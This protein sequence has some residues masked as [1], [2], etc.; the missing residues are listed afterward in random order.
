[1]IFYYI[2]FAFVIASLYAIFFFYLTIEW[3]KT[4]ELHVLPNFNL[5]KFSIIIPFKNESSNIR[6]CLDSIIRQNYPSDHYEIICVNDYSIDDGSSI[7]E[8]YTKQYSNIILINND[9]NGKKEAL[10]EGIAI[11][12]FNHIITTDADTTRQKSW[13]AAYASM[14]N[15]KGIKVVAGPVI[16]VPKAIAPIHYLQALDY[17][18][19]MALSIVAMRKHWFRNGSGANLAFTKDVYLS[20]IINTIDKNISSGDDVF[21]LQHAY[22]EHRNS[23][24]FPKI[25]D[26]AA[27]TPTEPDWRSFLKQRSRWASKSFAYKEWNMTLLWSFI[28]IAN[29]LLPITAILSIGSSVLLV[30]LLA[31]SVMTKLIADY[32]FLKSATNYYDKTF[33][34]YFFIAE[35]YH[36]NYVIIV[37]F[38]TLFRKT[39][40]WKGSKIT[41]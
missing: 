29:L 41:L 22:K 39:F 7:I 12:K 21:L 6:I 35:L 36:L 10:R 11:A 18:G 24:L 3:L 40:D 30:Q 19:S 31:F 16:M 17:C 8:T 23:I 1:M 15:Y 5:V 37:G 32:I 26:L 2:I 13:L 9:L 28:W 14:F 38:N 34:K 25:K 20:Y 33:F 27:F 4:R